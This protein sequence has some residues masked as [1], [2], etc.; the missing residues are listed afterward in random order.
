MRDPETRK[1][2]LKVATNTQEFLAA[3]E[4][5]RKL[6]GEKG[7]WSEALFLALR[8]DTSLPDREVVDR[9]NKDLKQAVTAIERLRGLRDTVFAEYE[10]V[11][12]RRAT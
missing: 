11:V 3:S 12:A 7:Q 4:T 9:L 6:Q 2:A 5:A 10:G 8:D 1:A